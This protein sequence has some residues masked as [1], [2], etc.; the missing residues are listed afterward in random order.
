MLASPMGSALCTSHEPE[1][2]QGEVSR[3]CRESEEID[4]VLQKR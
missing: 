1:E 3:L 4:S 2:Q